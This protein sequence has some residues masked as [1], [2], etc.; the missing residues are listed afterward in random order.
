MSPTLS[1]PGPSVSERGGLNSPP[2][3]PSIISQVT[4]ISSPSPALATQI[5][6]QTHKPTP[7]IVQ[8]QKIQQI[9]P[10]QQQ[11]KPISVILNKSPPKV[12]MDKIQPL[13]KRESG[14]INQQLLKAAAAGKV[15]F[16][17]KK[18]VKI[19]KMAP[20]TGSIQLASNQQQ[21]QQPQQQGTFTTNNKKVTIRL[22]E[23]QKLVKS[24]PGTFII[25]K[26]NG[27]IPG[28]SI[29]NE[30]LYRFLTNISHFFCNAGVRKL[31]RVQN[32]GN[33]N[34]S[35][36]ILL[37]VSFQDVKDFRT[38]KIINT[39]NLNSKSPN[40]K[41]AAANL[42][43]QSK[44]GL[45]PKNVLVPREQLIGKIELNEKSN[46]FENTYK[47]TPLSDD[48]MSDHTTSDDA[49]SYVFDDVM[50]QS[51]SIIAAAAAD[52]D[53]H[54]DSSDSAHET[55]SCN[56]SIIGGSNHTAADYP[57][58]M[59]T[60]EEKRLL[61]KEGISLPGNYPLTK[62]EER[63]LKRIR[64]KIRNKISAQDSRKRKKEYVD[65]LEERV[66]QCT[67]DNQTLMK[68]IKLLQNQNQNLMSQ[69]KKLQTLLTK[70]TSKTAQP[71][72]CLM[73]LLLSLALVAV[74][75]L[76]LGK[77]AKET[78]LA[79]ALQEDLLLN[80]RSLLFNSKEQMG[81]MLVDEEMNL[82]DILA[83]NEIS[84]NDNESATSD[85]N[86][87]DDDVIG[88]SMA[89]KSKQIVDFDV[90]DVVW[91]PPVVGLN[92]N[93]KNR[94]NEYQEYLKKTIGN[95]FMIDATK[96]D[97]ANRPTAGKMKTNNNNNR[98]MMDNMM[99]IPQPSSKLFDMNRVTT[100]LD[101]G[102]KSGL[103]LIGD[104]NIIIN[105]LSV[106]QRK[107]LNA[108]QI[109]DAGER[110]ILLKGV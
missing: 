8:Q 100:T 45:V 54:S 23:G 27:N 7:I 92:A 33:T 14:H 2:R 51:N 76:K 62:H 17:P 50:L 64:R 5:Q 60:N 58:L 79:T 75:N 66:K 90:D 74:P 4:P 36:S 71:A 68:R 95:G 107:K 12:I 91:K 81:D 18:E 103:D 25:N 108:S 52:V 56:G 53:H 82:D 105:N 69:M 61:S 10:Q 49:D 34:N 24:Q 37:P 97:N 65:G 80:R 48:S 1:S 19:I 89:K 102:S 22:P 11:P 93:F 85:D 47:K 13:P 59:L 30:N 70:G 26:N 67:D 20:A 3:C 57:K 44:Q 55:T 99:M 101:A 78:E 38:I 104:S 40:I 96:N 73:V 41:L 28:K 83:F 84:N 98:M 9:Q 77:N 21:L 94:A 16:L 87:D 15:N 6:I 63:E 86:D 39:S 31:I 110:K 42:L 32:A 46:S 29:L 106:E 35:R 88:V 72:T 43:Q 109:N